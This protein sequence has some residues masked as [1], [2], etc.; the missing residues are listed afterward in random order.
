MITIDLKKFCENDRCRPYLNNPFSIGDFTYASDGRIAVRVPRL[1]SVGEVEGAPDTI[2]KVFTENLI[3]FD[4]A[5]LVPKP[6]QV[7]DLSCKACKRT[8][9]VT[10]CETCGGEG[11]QECDLGHDHDCED[12]DGNGVI[13]VHPGGEKDGIECPECDGLGKIPDTPQG[14]GTGVIIDGKVGVGLGYLRKLADLP[15]VRWSLDHRTYPEAPIPF[16]F[17]GG[18]GILMPMRFYPDSENYLRV[19]TEETDAMVVRIDRIDR[20]DGACRA[21]DDTPGAEVKEHLD[22]DR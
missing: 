16:W 3:A 22:A 5:T 11:Y 15:L 8:G 12:C 19:D 2:L 17:D 1:E 18:E 14:L 7:A 13:A 21:D 6:P 4:Q 20:T 9:K 10:L